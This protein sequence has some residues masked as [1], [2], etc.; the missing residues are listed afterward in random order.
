MALIEDEDDFDDVPTL[1]D[2]IAAAVQEGV[3]KALAERDR[4]E[5]QK[6]KKSKPKTSKVTVDA[7]SLTI[8]GDVVVGGKISAKPE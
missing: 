7:D 4:K 3:T 2:I 5:A 1:E 6:A 8:T